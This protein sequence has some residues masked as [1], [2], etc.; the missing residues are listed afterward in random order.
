MARY[1]TSDRLPTSYTFTACHVTSSSSSSMSRGVR[2]Y[3]MTVLRILFKMTAR[4]SMKISNG[5]KSI[6]VFPTPRNVMLMKAY[7]T[8]ST[9]C[10][11]LLNGAAKSDVIGVGIS[12][13]RCVKSR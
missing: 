13:M 7:S 1:T 8:P 10:V 12:R 2:R 4:G 9:K 11:L 5:F 3:K 6:N